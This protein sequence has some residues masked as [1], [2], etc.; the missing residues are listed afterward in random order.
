MN[1]KIIRGCSSYDLFMDT[2]LKY[3]YKEVGFIAVVTINIFSQRKKQADK[4][5]KMVLVSRMS[6]ED[7]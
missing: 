6:Q 4:H 2:N 5:Q 3:T 7:P 1:F